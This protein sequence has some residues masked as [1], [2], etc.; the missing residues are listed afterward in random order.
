MAA[1]DHDDS[2]PVPDPTTL[3]TEALLR[4]IATLSTLVDQKFVAVVVRLDAMDAAMAQRQKDIDRIPDLIETRSRHER[5]LTDET[6]RAIGRRFDDNDRRLDQESENNKVAVSAAFS[7][8]KEAAREQNLA[9]EKALD[10]S[11]AATAEAIAKL[12]ALFDSGIRAVNDKIDDLRTRQTA[13]EASRTGRESG[14][15]HASSDAAR[16][17]TFAFASLAAV[18]SIIGIGLGIL[19]ATGR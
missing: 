13:F 14:A 17:R 12:G 10:K 7:A 8:Q 4:E 2:R 9:S 5:E 18:A 11:E 16:I 6:H 15:E 19:A 1:T 3:T